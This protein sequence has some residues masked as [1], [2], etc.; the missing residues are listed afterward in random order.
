LLP[1]VLHLPAGVDAPDVENAGL[2]VDVAPLERQPL[3]A[4][5]PCVDDDHRQR[6][7]EL[8]CDRLDLLPRRERGDLAPLRLR[9]P[10]LHR[11]VVGEHAHRDG[12]VQELP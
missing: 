3:L 1:V 12:V 6:R 5:E 4:A 9:I 11:R 7:P 8:L 10:H 2:A